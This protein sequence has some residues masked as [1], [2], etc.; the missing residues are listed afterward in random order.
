MLLSCLFVY[1]C[2][3]LSFL[4]SLSFPVIFFLSFPLFPLIFLLLFI[5]LPFASF[6][7]YLFPF[8]VCFILYFFFFFFRCLFSHFF[9]HFSLPFL[10][11]FTSLFFYHSFFFPSN[12]SFVYHCFLFTPFFSVLFPQHKTRHYFLSFCHHLY[13]PQDLKL[14]KNNEIHQVTFFF[15]RH[16]PRISS[17]I[18][19]LSANYFYVPVPLAPRPALPRPVPPRAPPESGS[20]TKWDTCSGPKTA[21][22]SARSGNYS[23]SRATP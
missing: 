7:I 20:S 11:L 12:H 21:S 15:I 14:K 8:I 6:F 3:V 10:F 1:F 23:V 2:L 13:N 16:T 22:A 5:S 17:M 18:I 9:S 4:P 19:H